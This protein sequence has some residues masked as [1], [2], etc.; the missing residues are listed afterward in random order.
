MKIENILFDLDGTLTDPQPGI[1]RSIQYA[2]EKLGKP[3]P[4]VEDLL[5]CIGPPCWEALKKY[6]PQMPIK[7][8]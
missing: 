6:W 2:L 7:Q 8:K 5:W 4:A 1:T 3:V